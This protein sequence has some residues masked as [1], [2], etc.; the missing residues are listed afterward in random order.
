M[1]A[2]P[3]DQVLKKILQDGQRIAV[4]GLSPVAGR[5]SFGVTRYM[6]DQGY[7]IFGVRPASPTE[8]LGRPCVESIHQLPGPVDILNVFRNVDAIP[9]LVDD[10]IQWM[11]GLPLSDKPK[12]L[13]LQEG[14]THEAAE[15][16]AR[17]AGLTVVSD[18]C[19]LKEHARLI[20]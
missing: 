12:V 3:N 16:K 7:E 6:I 14:I 18:R 4:I 5:P 2:Q 9:G 8:V 17:K 11:K 13:W 15:E 1:S 19:I 10:I 20:H